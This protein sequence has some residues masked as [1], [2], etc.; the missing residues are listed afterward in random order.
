MAVIRPRTHDALMTWTMPL[1]GLPSLNV[2]FMG[3][4][5]TMRTVHCSKQ[6]STF[7]SR[8]RPII[9]PAYIRSYIAGRTL[10]LAAAQWI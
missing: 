2:K 7:P 4:R 3:S 8:N 6:T 9:Q 1:L 10:G 5:L